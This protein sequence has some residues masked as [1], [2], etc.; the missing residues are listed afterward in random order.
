MDHGSPDIR[1]SLHCRPTAS[2][3]PRVPF[4]HESFPTSLESDLILLTKPCACGSFSIMKLVRYVS[5]PSVRHPQHALRIVRVRE[6][7][8]NARCRFLMKCA[9]ETV[10]I[11]LKNGKS[12]RSI[13]SRPDLQP[14]PQTVIHAWQK[15][16]KKS[17]AAK[18]TPSQVQSFM[19][20]SR[21]CRLR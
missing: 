9:N 14:Q 5:D 6:L 18:V 16:K 8:T 13:P 10:T 21:R 4:T 11:E 15:Q 2:S 7:P 3:N 20:P 12:S 19:A 1:R 17:I